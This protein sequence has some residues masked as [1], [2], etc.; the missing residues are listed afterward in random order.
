MIVEMELQVK[1]NRPVDLEKDY[2]VP[3]GYEMIMNGNSVEFDFCHCNSGISNEDSS[4]VIFNANGMDYAS[5]PN[6]KR[7]R[8][9]DLKN[10]SS[11]R[12]CFVYTGEPGES[13]LKVESIK[14]ILFILPHSKPWVI[15]VP[16]KPINNFNKLLQAEREKEKKKSIYEIKLTLPEMKE[17][18]MAQ[19]L[20]FYSRFLDIPLEKL[21]GYDKEQLEILVDS[22]L[23]QMPD[24][25][26]HEFELELTGG[27]AEE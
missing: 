2:I 9:K 1:F 6:L 24:D 5:F 4:V 10:I 8:K 16:Q 12:E 22:T 15:E 25:I 13:D 18:I 27:K 23:M 19:Q 7:L 21:C 17:K 20:T 14:S 3:G 11:I 26:L